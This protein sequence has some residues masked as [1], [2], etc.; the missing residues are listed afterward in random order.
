MKDDYQ[1]YWYFSF[2]LKYQKNVSVFSIFPQTPIA[3]VK[4]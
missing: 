2:E 1:M 4:E 3:V